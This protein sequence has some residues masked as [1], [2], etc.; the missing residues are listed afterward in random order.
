MIGKTISHYKVLEKIG[1]G[2][3]GE[4]FL[5]QDTTLDRKVAMKF[6]PEQMLQN[7]TARKRF[8]REAKSAAALNHPYICK[9]YEVGESEGKSFIS[10]EYIQG[11][12]LQEQLAKGPLPLKDALRTSVE[13]A[14][15]LEGAHKSNIVHRDLKPSNIMLTPEGHVK[16]MDFGLAKRITRVEGQD[17]EEITTK[18]TKDDSILGTVPYMSPEQL[19]GQEVDARSDIFSFGVA[20]YEM[21]TGVHPFKKSGHMETAHAVLSETAPPLSRYTEDI[22]LLLQHTV[23]KMLAKEPSQRYQ[24]IHD[25]RTDL[26]ELMDDIVVSSTNRSETDSV[27]RTPRELATAEGQR[28]WRR[29]VP[30]LVVCTVL[31][32]VVASFGVWSVLR[33]VTSTLP[34]PRRFSI[35]ISEALALDPGLSLSANGQYLAYLTGAG[36]D[37]AL[38]LRP[39]DQLQVTRLATRVESDSFFS[40]DGQSLGFFSWDEGLQKVSLPAGT[41]ITLG[42]IL[43]DKGGGSWGPDNTIVLS[44][45]GV[46]YRVSATGGNPE[47]LLSPDQEEGETLYLY[48]EFLPGGTALL[49]TVVLSNS[50]FLIAVLSLETGEKTIVLEQG[51]QGYYA[52]TGNLVYSLPDTGVLMAAP[53]SVERLEV[54]GDPVPVF[55]DIR[56]TEYGSTHYSLARDG[57]LAYVPLRDD[58]QQSL[59]WVDRDGTERLVTETK[60]DYRTPRVSPDGTRI[61][62]GIGQNIWIYD[63]EL[64]SFTRLTFE[65]INGRPIW[66][67]DGKWII[68]YSRTDGPINLYQ[69]PADGSGEVERLTTSEFRQEP[70]SWSPDGSLLSFFELHLGTKGDIMTLNLNEK[71]EPKTW[72]DA[73]GGECCSAFSPDGQWV[74]YVSDVRVY[75]SPYQNSE[76]KWLIS[77]EDAF[78]PVWSPDGRELFYRSGDRMM[79]VPVETNPTFTAGKPGVLFEGL[80]MRAPSLA[81]GQNWDISPDGQQFVMIKEDTTSDQINVVLNW[82]E[83]LK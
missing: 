16:V 15:A 21:L 33:P 82:F 75:V 49:F 14:E 60:Q 55:E 34:S 43:G 54:T 78:G 47:I 72:S 65:G 18:L 59:V 26:S 68:F 27:V 56:H 20:L 35:S 31:S 38:Y 80:Y 39:M 4:V 71:E 3:M 23:K 29:M 30:W 11:E 77:G 5:A 66:T 67:P 69:K 6:L 22:P 83:E 1:Q 24:L 64:D 36:I 19:R 74:A 25:V 62:L 53:F 44:A 17:E 40:P 28:S 57:T 58:P 41:P 10:M 51:K 73:P 70:F 7:P 42:E 46:L 81:G 2:G 8:L 52:P 13:I 48:P 79:V 63:I 76:V 12:T 9:I 37:K 50:D 61:A 45:G 32:A